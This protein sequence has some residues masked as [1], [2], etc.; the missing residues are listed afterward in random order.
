MK[1]FQFSFKFYSNNFIFV[2]DKPDILIWMF[3][4]G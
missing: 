4:A 1:D 2:S 3:Y